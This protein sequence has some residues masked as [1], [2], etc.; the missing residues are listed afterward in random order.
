MI[1]KFLITAKR[2][3]FLYNSLVIKQFLLTLKFIG[4]FLNIFMKNKNQFF[5]LNFKYVPSIQNNSHIL[6][7]LFILIHKIL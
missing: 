4:I 2:S 6:V 3:G 1:V 7:I 5:S